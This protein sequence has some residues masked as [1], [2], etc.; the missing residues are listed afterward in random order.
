MKRL[1]AMQ[2]GSWQML[3]V[4]PMVQCRCSIASRLV[5]K[6]NV[7]VSGTSGQVNLRGVEGDTRLSERR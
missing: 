7:K 1:Y 6:V 5:G 4:E 3:K 2:A